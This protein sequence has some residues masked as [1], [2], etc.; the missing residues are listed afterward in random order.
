MGGKEW[1]RPTA[2]HARRGR[3]TAGHGGRSRPTVGHAGRGRP[4]AGQGWRGCGASRWSK[5]EVGWAW[6][7]R[8]RWARQAQW[9]LGCLKV[10]KNS[11]FKEFIIFRFRSVMFCKGKLG[12]IKENMAAYDDSI[13]RHIITF[14]PSMIGWI[15]QE[16][17]WSRS[18]LE[19]VNGG[20]RME[21]ITQT[22]KN[23][24]DV[25]KMA[26]FGIECGGGFD[27]RGVYLEEYCEDT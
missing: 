27:R 13:A 25:Y 14:I 15:T 9:Y 22:S 5:G 8:R 16:D 3:P 17:T 6:A 24:K 10:R 21:R 19:F 20:G 18:S 2:G 12:F 4:T 11:R 7:C 1:R 26:L 23:S